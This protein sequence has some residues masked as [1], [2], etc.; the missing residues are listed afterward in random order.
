MSILG[1]HLRVQLCSKNVIKK[2]S[3]IN[4]HFARRDYALCLG[5]KLDLSTDEVQG[6]VRQVKVPG[7]ERERQILELGDMR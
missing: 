7:L 6:V 3:T 5:L 1:E 4:V 2:G